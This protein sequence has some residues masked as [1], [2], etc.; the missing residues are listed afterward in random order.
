MKTTRYATSDKDDSDNSFTSSKR[1]KTQTEV[2]PKKRVV[3]TLNI[4]DSDSDVSPEIA[5][6]ATLEEP[7]DTSVIH[8]ASNELNTSIVPTHGIKM[9]ADLSVPFQSAEIEIDDSAAN[10]SDHGTEIGTPFTP[11][12]LR[13]IHTSPRM[14]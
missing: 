4:V 6:E 7:H 1:A 12:S 13:K 9:E 8:K 14:T 2:R 3:R 10:Q 5:V 11:A